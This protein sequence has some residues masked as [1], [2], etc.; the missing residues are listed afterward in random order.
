VEIGDIVDTP[1]E[2]APPKRKRSSRAARNG[3][4]SRNGNGVLRTELETL[5]EGLKELRDGDF[6]VR[7]PTSTDPLIAEIYAAFN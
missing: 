2:T 3:N 5:L 1:E 6:D 7:L 4:G